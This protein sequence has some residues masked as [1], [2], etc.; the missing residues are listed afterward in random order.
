MHFL[1]DYKATKYLYHYTTEKALCEG[2]AITKSLKFGK[3]E[4]TNDPK[5]YYSPTVGI[6]GFPGPPSEIDSKVSSELEKYKLLCFSMDDTESGLLGYLKPRMWAQYANKHRG[7]CLVFN[8]EKLNS[9]I[10][11]IVESIDNLEFIKVDGVR[12]KPLIDFRHKAF[13]YSDSFNVGLSAF[14]KSYVRDN[15]KDFLFTKDFDWK[16]ENEFRFIIYDTKGPDDIFLP[17]KD[18]LSGI[19]FGN[20]FPELMEKRD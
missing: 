17:I 8:Y 5:E 3:L 11:R 4:N 13:K 20:D 18:S 9:N 14:T 7:C 2:I 10:Y 6:D 12:Y 1:K 15:I 19:V 16:S